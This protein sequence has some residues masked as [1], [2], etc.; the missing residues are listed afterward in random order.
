[1]R[2]MSRSLLAIVILSITIGLLAIA[3]GRIFSAVEDRN[4]REQRQRPQQEREFA[5]NVDTL[6]RTT[7]SPVITAYGEISSRRTLELRAAASGTLIEISDSFRNGGFVQTGDLLF[8]IDPA[9]AQSARDLAGAEVKEAEAE[10]IE[11]TAALDLAKA[12]LDAATQQTALRDQAVARQLDLK[13][14]GVGSDAAVEAARL[15]LSSA[16]QTELSRKQALAGAKARILRAELGQTRAA[17]NLDE[18]ERRLAETNVTA[19]FDGILNNVAS[20]QGRLVNSN[21]QLGELIDIEALEIAF[22]V[23]NSQFSRLIDERGQIRPVDVAATLD[24]AGAPIEVTG[25]VDRANAEVGAGQTGREIF[26]TI[27]P[28]DARVLR[29]GDFMRVDIA[30]PVLENVSVIPATAATS[31]GRILL[32][33]DQ[34][35]LEE[36]QVRILR[37]QVD[38]LIISQAPFDKDFVTKLQPQLGAGVKVKPVRPDAVIEENKMVAITEEQREAFT[39]RIE[40]NAY[41]PE[42]AKARIL[43]RLKEDEIPQDM[44]DRMN[45]GGRQNGNQTASDD[46]GERETNGTE[47]AIA[48]DDDRRARLIAFVEGNSRMPAD[49]KTRVLE[50]LKAEQVPAAM[51]ERIESRM[52]G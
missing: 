20:V 30:E 31:D 33:N 18:A 49:A 26:A 51:V 23:S 39:K 19:P 5:V 37:R 35:R 14:R 40:A 38:T 50:Q 29:P 52:G 46:A 1:M 2:F 47:N 45:G 4:S 25:R 11:A 48:L 22:R 16:T 3:A 27:D 28:D 15:S 17:I 6:T 41:I 8:R 36:A 34:D 32:V 12:E 10:L 43:A 42:D 13:E 7:A 9:D 24:L 44:F 21:E